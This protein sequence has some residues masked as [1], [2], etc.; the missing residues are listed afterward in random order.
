MPSMTFE[1]SHNNNLMV[2]GDAFNHRK[3]IAV[4]TKSS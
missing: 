4:T 3:V 2:V 1:G